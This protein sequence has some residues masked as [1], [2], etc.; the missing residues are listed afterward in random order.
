MKA[1]RAFGTYRSPSL[2]TG[3]AC[4]LRVLAPHRLARCLS[5][6]MGLIFPF[7]YVSPSHIANNGLSAV[8]DVDLFDRYFPRSFA[9]MAVQGF[10]QSRVRA[11]QFARVI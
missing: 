1:L 6:C 3:T 2:A 11:S 9:A 5:E 7:G 4:P 10:E 8:V